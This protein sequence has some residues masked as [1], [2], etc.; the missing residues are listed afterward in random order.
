MKLLT[1]LSDVFQKS[2][3]TNQIRRSAPPSTWPLSKFSSKEIKTCL[4]TNNPKSLQ[5]D[6]E[7]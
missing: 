2:T 7:E 3:T 6:W 4:R 1:H 5:I